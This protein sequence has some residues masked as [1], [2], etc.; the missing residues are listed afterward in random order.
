MTQI[1]TTTTIDDLIR[2]SFGHL[3]SP[4]DAL[5]VLNDVG[6]DFNQQLL[7]MGYI[8]EPEQSATYD[9]DGDG[10]NDAIQVVYHSDDGTMVFS[11]DEVRSMRDASVWELEN[12]H[13]QEIR[14]AAQDVK[15]LDALLS[16]AQ[17]SET[18][19]HDYGTAES[20][21]TTQ[22]VQTLLKMAT[23]AR[24]DVSAAV[25]NE[26]QLTR[27]FIDQVMAQEE[28]VKFDIGDGRITELNVYNL[29]GPDAD[30]FQLFPVK[31]IEN[32][33]V[34]PPEQK[35]ETPKSTGKNKRA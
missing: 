24:R 10:Q 9:F 3:A 12:G 1:E 32:P 31:R 2:S 16:G 25:P 21:E 35:E 33:A 29:P 22:T 26:H 34:K 27:Y 20:Q 11:L 5:A 18:A 23:Q 19:G 30:P 7:A 28:F 15:N 8:Q 17:W 14:D 13:T 6:S 4:E